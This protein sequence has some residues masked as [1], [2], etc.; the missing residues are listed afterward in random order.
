MLKIRPKPAITQQDLKIV[1]LHFDSPH[2]YSG[3]S[4]EGWG[5][6]GGIAWGTDSI[7]ETKNKLSWIRSWSRPK[8]IWTKN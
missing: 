1:D 7:I 2:I 5:G 4:R 8:L 6:V 3:G